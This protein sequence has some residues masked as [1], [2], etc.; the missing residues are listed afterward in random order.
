MSTKRTHFKSATLVAS[1][2]STKNILAKRLIMKVKHTIGFNP[3]V[4][5]I[6][7]QGIRTAFSQ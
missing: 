4:L 2:D 7:S 5:D 3:S 1:T 6:Q